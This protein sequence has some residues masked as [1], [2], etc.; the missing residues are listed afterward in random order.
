MEVMKPIF[1]DLT[2]PKLIENDVI[3]KT[4]LRHSTTCCGRGVARH[5][6][7]LGTYDF[8]VTF[9]NGNQSSIQILEH[10]GLGHKESNTIWLLQ[11]LDSE[12][13][14]RAGM[15]QRKPG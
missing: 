10:L 8:I 13:I 9:S 5:T 12:G 4:S 1:K 7:E 6:L 15:I 14:N 3:G 11:Q 2:S